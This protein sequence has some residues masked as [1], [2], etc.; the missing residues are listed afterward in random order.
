[1]QLRAHARIRGRG[2]THTHNLQISSL[3]TQKQS[4]L[5]KLLSLL[6]LEAPGAWRI[7]FRALA[8]DGRIHESGAIGKYLAAKM[9]ST[10]AS[11]R[12]CKL[13]D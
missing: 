9:D 12:P 6:A 1:M 10:S 5:V 8:R 2:L 4:F 3:L 13:V 11:W 7:Q